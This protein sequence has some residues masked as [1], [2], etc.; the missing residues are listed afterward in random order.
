MRAHLGKQIKDFLCVASSFL[1]T[2]EEADLKA[3]ADESI[4]TPVEE[5][6]EPE[7]LLKDPV[8][9]DEDYY[10]DKDESEAPSVLSE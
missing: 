8:D 1:L 4:D 6:V 5:S 10:Y 3:F 2:L 9:D 7:E